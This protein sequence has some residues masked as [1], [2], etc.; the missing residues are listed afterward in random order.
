MCVLGLFSY[1]RNEP[2]N[3]EPFQ[4]HDTWAVFEAV[5]VLHFISRTTPSLTSPLVFEATVE[6]FVDKFRQCMI[7]PIFV[8]YAI[9][10]VSRYFSSNRKS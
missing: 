6:D 4:L 3:F 1:I 9:Y 2:D 8:F 7:E 10:E 5:Y